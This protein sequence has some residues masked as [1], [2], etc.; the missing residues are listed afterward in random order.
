MS[1]YYYWVCIFQF[2]HVVYGSLLAKVKLK[3]IMLSDFLWEKG[4]LIMFMFIRSYNYYEKQQWYSNFA[5]KILLMLYSTFFLHN[6]N[7]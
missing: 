3:Y 1:Y 2:L 5:K 4:R 7:S 6:L